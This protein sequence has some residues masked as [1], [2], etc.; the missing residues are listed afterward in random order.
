[1]SVVRLNTVPC[2]ANHCDWRL[3]NTNEL[4]TLLDYG[5]NSPAINPLFNSAGSFTS[6]GLY[7]SSTTYQRPTE[8]AWFV[9]FGDGGLMHGNNKTFPFSVQAVRGGQ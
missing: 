4:L 8:Y 2:F 6:D 3:P 1:M 9:G 7:W 5:Q